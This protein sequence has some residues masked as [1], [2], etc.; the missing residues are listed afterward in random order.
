MGSKLYLLV[1][2]LKGDQS[3]PII[4]QGPA[5]FHYKDL[6]DQIYDFYLTEVSVHKKLFGFFK[7]LSS[8]FNLGYW[9]VDSITLFFLLE[10]LQDILKHEG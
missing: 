4:S 10:I 1:E 8:P 3:L 7:A 2:I 9:A 5:E 6:L